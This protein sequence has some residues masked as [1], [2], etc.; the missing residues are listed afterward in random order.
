MKYVVC[1]RHKVTW[2]HVDHV[3]SAQRGD[4][5]SQYVVNVLVREKVK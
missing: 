2:D 1:W 4:G 3:L 5:F